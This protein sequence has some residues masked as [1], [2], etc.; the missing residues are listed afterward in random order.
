VNEHLTAI[1]D[2]ID[3]SIANLQDRFVPQARANQQYVMTG[4]NNLALML[5]EAL[6]QMQQQMQQ[7]KQGNGQCQKPG[8]G[9][10]GPS[11]GDLKK[12]QEK[13]SEQ[14]KKMKEGMKPGP[15]EKGKQ[16][17]GMSEELA[18]MAA[19]QEA[20]RNALRQLNEEENKDGQ[21]KLGDLGRIMKQMEENE[22]DI[23]NKKITDAT[24]KR[25]QE[26]LTRLLESEKAEREREQ[27]ERRESNEGQAD[28]MRNPS[29]FEEYKRLKLRE[30][31]LLKTIPPSLTTFY[32]NLVNSYFQSLEN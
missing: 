4:A 5:S 22:K 31:E 32:K 21:G 18:K 26:I 23:V 20:I 3:K 24:L 7:M 9:K 30:L 25:Q 29:Q 17:E 11:A 19:Q 13:L 27:E 8:K 10:P 15:G 1:N 6:D 28:R 16:G 14:L 12:M 2:N